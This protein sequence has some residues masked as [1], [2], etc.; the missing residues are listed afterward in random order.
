[1]PLLCWSWRFHRC[2]SSRNRC[3]PKVLTGPGRTCPPGGTGGKL[4]RSGDQSASSRRIK[5][6]TAPVLEAPPVVVESV[7]PA[8][9]REYVVPAPAGTCAHVA[10]A[11]VVEYAAPAPTVAYAVSVTIMTAAPT[12]FPTVTEVR[13]R[14]A[15]A[16]NSSVD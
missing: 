12:V 2:N 3:D 15:H 16:L 10:A 14:G 1:M 13:Q 8:P 4:W 6:V 11:P 5:F 7:Q 9:L